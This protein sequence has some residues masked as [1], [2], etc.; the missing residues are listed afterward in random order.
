MNSKFITDIYHKPTDAH[1]YLHYNSSHPDHVFKG[2]VYGQGLRYRR[3][4]SDDDTFKSRLKE[5]A[6]HFINCGY[7]LN[8][9]IKPIFD[10]I[11]VMERS[12]EYNNS[13]KDQPFL[14][15]FLYTYGPGNIEFKQYVNKTVNDALKGAESFKN[16]ETPIIKTV[17]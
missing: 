16:I 2:I 5:L 14:V 11:A 17:F 13:T 9:L 15:P 3:I 10:K 8:T 12:L 4:I 7:P 1:R 6:G